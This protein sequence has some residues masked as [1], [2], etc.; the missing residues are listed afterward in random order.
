LRVKELRA[1]YVYELRCPS[2]RSVSGQPLLHPDAYYTLNR[3][4]RR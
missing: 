3:V 4:P 2:L 1:G